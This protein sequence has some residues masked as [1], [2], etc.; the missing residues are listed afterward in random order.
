MKESRKVIM[1]ESKKC[2][3]GCGQDAIKQFKNSMYC[4][5]EYTNQCPMIRKKNSNNR[6]G[7]N[8]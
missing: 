7:I 5:S 4:C 8:P 1:L 2:D 6:K 3:Y